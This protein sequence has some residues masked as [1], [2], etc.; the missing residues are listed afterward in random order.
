MGRPDACKPCHSGLRRRSLWGQEKYMPTWV[1]WTHV[2]PAFGA[3]GGAHCGA[4]ERVMGCAEMCRAD[5]R[6]PSH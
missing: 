4:T 3:F 1:A 5:A 6:K 2:N